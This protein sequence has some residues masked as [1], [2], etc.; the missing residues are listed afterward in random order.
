MISLSLISFDYDNE[1]HH[2]FIK[3]QH[4][5]IILILGPFEHHHFDSNRTNDIQSRSHFALRN[6]ETFVQ[7]E[8]LWQRHLKLQQYINKAGH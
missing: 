1:V 2:N 8:T 4:E 6:T 5:T 7:F 3:T